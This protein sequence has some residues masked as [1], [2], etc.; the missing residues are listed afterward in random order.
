MSLNAA[1]QLSQWLEVTH[2][3]LFAV[4]YQRALTARN[5]RALRSAS[6]RGFGDDTSDMTT[7][8][9]VADAVPPIDVGTVPAG[10]LASPGVSAALTSDT[11]S[12]FDTGGGG[13]LQSIGAGITSAASSVGNFLASPQGLNDLTKLGTAYF[14]VQNNKIN[15]QLQTAV[16]NAQI[17]RASQG[18]STL[19][20]TYARAPNGSMVPVY[21]SS[22]LASEGIYPSNMPT[23][24]QFAITSGQSKLITLPDGTTAYT[25]PSN[26]VGSLGSNLSMSQMLPWIVLLGA[27]L[28][29]L[30]R[31]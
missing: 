16:L 19:P 20:V 23:S 10:D 8:D 12:T 17:S 31:M 5:T 27:G 26:I 9:V 21:T 24:L 11:V 2:P 14:Q 7:V 28:L 3:E 18:L 4:L 22:S 25:V 1:Q 15:A 29:F 30:K 13:F 6:L